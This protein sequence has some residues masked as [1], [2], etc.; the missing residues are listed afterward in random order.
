MK[1]KFTTVQGNVFKSLIEAIKEIVT[2]TNIEVSAK[3]IKLC[4]TD[5]SL[6]G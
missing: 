3:G 6:A 2:E 5:A 1:F 4:A